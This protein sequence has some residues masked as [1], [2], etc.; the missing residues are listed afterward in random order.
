MRALLVSL[1]FVLLAGC[2]APGP[3]TA[4]TSCERSR[5]AWCAKTVECET[6]C[7]DKFNIE[8]V[9]QTIDGCVA[10]IKANA[11]SRPGVESAHFCE[12]LRQATT[13]YEACTIAIGRVD[14]ATACPEP[15]D[16]GPFQNRMAFICEDAGVNVTP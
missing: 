8:G 6:L 10:A 5:I 2:D 13:D 16:Y 4:T 7:L 15:S 12:T 3:D 9:R 11:A 14:C 1:S